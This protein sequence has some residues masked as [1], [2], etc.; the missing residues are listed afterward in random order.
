[1]EILTGFD[2]LKS[3]KTTLI[4]GEEF[5]NYYGYSMPNHYRILQENYMI[6]RNCFNRIEVFHRAAGRNL[7]IAELLF[8]GEHSEYIGL[9]ELLSLEE[10]INA[11]KN[12]YSNDDEIHK[13]GFA[14]IG[15]CIDNISLLVG[16]S[17][18]NADNIYLE[19]SSLFPSGDRFLFVAQNIFEFIRMLS[20]VERE[21]IGYG[22]TGYESLYRNWGEDFWR[23]R[24]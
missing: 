12:A 15:E 24:E 13:M 10:S 1:M 2:L 23:V 7:N 8:S 16:L 5:V 22:L 4:A 11:M 3:R 18:D 20:L 17:N 14:M 19:N 21:Y 6:C 9:Y